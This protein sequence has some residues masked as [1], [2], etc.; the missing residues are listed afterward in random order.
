MQLRICI[1]AA[2]API[3]WASVALVDETIKIGL[4][5]AFTGSSSPR[6]VSMRDRVK[7]AVSEINKSGGVL[8]KQNR[9]R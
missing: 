6:G 9:T 1:F 5:G 2:A 4:S 3:A 8:G 7:L